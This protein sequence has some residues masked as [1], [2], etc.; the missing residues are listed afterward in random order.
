[1]KKVNCKCNVVICTDYVT[2]DKNE[3]DRI[4]KRVSEIVSASYRRG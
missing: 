4:L 3:V 1:M 2:K